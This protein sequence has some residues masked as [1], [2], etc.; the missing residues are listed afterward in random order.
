[1]QT[2]TVRFAAAQPGCAEDL[3]TECGK[4]QRIQSLCRNSEPLYFGVV[5]A[6][7]AP[8]AALKMD[9][10]AT[11][12]YYTPS[13]KL[14]ACLCISAPCQTVNRPLRQDTTPTV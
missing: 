5:A 6:V 10:E 2:A 1:M 14:Q 4:K 7:T 13:G 12:Q 9:S 11:Q 8:S 3:A